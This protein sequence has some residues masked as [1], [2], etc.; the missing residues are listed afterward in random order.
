MVDKT[1]NIKLL[2]DPYND[3]QIKTVPLPYLSAA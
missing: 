1:E 3:R 2:K